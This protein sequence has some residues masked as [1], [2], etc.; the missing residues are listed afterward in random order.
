MYML[1]MDVRGRANLTPGRLTPQVDPV[2]TCPCSDAW[3]HDMLFILVSNP[4]PLRLMR[5][6]SNSARVPTR[7]TGE[8]R[9]SVVWWDTPPRFELYRCGPVTDP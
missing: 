8:P 9:A 1:Y 2:C 4:A 6:V 5:R 3:H 7:H